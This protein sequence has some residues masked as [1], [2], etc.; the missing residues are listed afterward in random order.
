[1]CV[2]LFERRLLG[3]RWHYEGMDTLWDNG[4]QL[5]GGWTA[6]GIRGSRYRLA[7]VGDNRDGAVGSYE[8]PEVP[9]A[10]RSGL[11]Q[12]YIIDLYVLDG[13]PYE[14][15]HRMRNSFRQYTPSGEI[16]VR[17]N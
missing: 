4:L 17:E 9:E 10:T 15:F 11:E 6:G 14:K 13:E 7:V 5:E 1:M 3:L 2:A 8:L 16:F 12:D